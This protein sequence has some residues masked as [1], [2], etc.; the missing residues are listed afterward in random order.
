MKRL[1]PISLVV[2][3]LATLATGAYAPA[4]HAADP[5]PLPSAVGANNPLPSIP[6]GASDSFFSP[7]MSR[8]MILFAWLVGVAALTLDNA[9]YYTVV[10]MGDYVHNLSAIG[11]AWRVLRDI[12][13]IA[14]IFGFLAVGITIILNVDWYGG[15][16]KLLPMLLIAAVFLNFSLFVSEAVIDVGNLF[17]TQIYTQINGG[18]L[19]GNKGSS[20]AN[21]GISDAI[22]AKLGLQGIYNDARRNGNV[23]LAGNSWVIGFMGILLFLVTAFVMFSL[24]FVLIARFVML[25]FLIILAPVGFAGIAIPALNRSARRWWSTLFEQMLTAPVLL[26]LLYIALRVILDAQFL[27]GFGPTSPDAWTSWIGGGNVASYGSLLLSFLVAMGLLL[28]VTMYAKTLSAFGASWA[29]RM[30]GRLSFGITGQLG[31]ATV[32]WG[33]KRFGDLSRRIGLARVPLVGTG[34]TRSFDRIGKSS[35]DVRGTSALKLAGIDAGTAQRGGYQADLKRRIETRTTYAATLTGRELNDEEKVRQAVLQNQIKDKQKER[36]RATDPAVIEKLDRDIKGL[37]ND[38]ERVESVTDQGAQRKYA[39]A[40]N[41]WTDPKN[42]FNR[43]FNFAS[44]TEAAKR[45]RG[46][47]KRGKPDRD[48][49]ANMRKLLRD[50]AEESEGGAG[51]GA[52]AATPPAGGPA[53]AP[54]PGPAAPPGGATPAAPAP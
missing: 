21:E 47:A 31:R 22:M 34:I 50:A 10:R 53:G 25:I 9:V 39:S 38:L 4:V 16:K 46:E 17:A 26:L 37:E 3:A 6:P 11:I 52:G 43:W 35:F 49:T 30:G 18:T 54:P 44:N 2:I 23:L 41:L 1:L 7:I 28:A 33:G 48:W 27:T 13:N 20:T 12:G 15:G 5:T 32:G 36:A 42:R 51:A 40:L 24:A 19:A 45:I 29:T 8:I 14:L